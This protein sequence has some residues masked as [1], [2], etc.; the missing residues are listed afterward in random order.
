MKEQT[1]TFKNIF[2]FCDFH[3]LYY[4][5]AQQLNDGDQIAEIGVMYGHSTAYMSECLRSM[6]KQV[7]F[8]S[9]DMWDDVGVPEFNK[10]GDE[11]LTS[12]FG[13]NY[14]KDIKEDP[15]IFYKKFLENMKNSG[16]LEHIIPLKLS[17]IEASKLIENESL[18]FC[19]IDAN[20]TYDFVKQDIH[21]WKYK[22][23]KGGV[24]AGHDYYWD[25]VKKAVDEIFPE[26]NIVGTSWW[27]LID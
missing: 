14:M 18:S 5:I 6:N 16:N 1:L 20:H 9:I 21:H 27:V 19:F 8:Y 26:A 22:V 3:D 12:I 17:S 10:E 11:I 7:T 15:N 25:G 24:L 23:R 2:G 13:I 4:N